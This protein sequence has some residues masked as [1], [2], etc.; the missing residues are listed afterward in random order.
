M[1]QLA[2][3]PRASP[4]SV[5]LGHGGARARDARLD[6]ALAGDSGADHGAPEPKRVTTAL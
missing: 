3:M 4:T 1:S 5:G 6:E 2:E